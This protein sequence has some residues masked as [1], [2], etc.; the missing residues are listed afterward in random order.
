[1]TRVIVA[2]DNYIFREGLGELLAARAG[3]DVVG[4]CGDLEALLEAVEAQRPDVV[5]TDIRMPPTRTDRG[6]S[7]GNAAA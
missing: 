1:M 2:D 4:A 6:H 7:G 3:M 5:I